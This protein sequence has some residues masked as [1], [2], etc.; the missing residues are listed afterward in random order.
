MQEEQLG[1]IYKKENCIQ[2]HACEVACKSWRGVE[3]GVKWRR[4]VNIWEGAYPD[5][6]CF[7][8]S[9][10]CMHCVEPA[11]VN[12]CPEEA[13]AKRREDG[14]VLVDSEKC[15]GCRT[16][17]KACPFG[18]PQFG[19]NSRMQ[20]CD[21]CVGQKSPGSEGPPCAGTCP[22]G[23]LSF[24]RVDVGKKKDAE[25]SVAALISSSA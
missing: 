7:S 6:K 5:V 23:A 20:K 16:C 10:S 13:I 22:T 9:I 25:R 24:M 2:C 14:I 21:M 3:F 1:F 19:G 12:A 8:V 15:V 4:V 11:C 18:V 17:F